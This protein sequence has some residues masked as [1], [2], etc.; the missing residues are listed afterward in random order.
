ML[1]DT[2]DFLHNSISNTRSHIIFSI[3]GILQR[4]FYING[5]IKHAAY[6]HS[7]CQHLL[8]LKCDM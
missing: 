1:F 2:F 5:V 8:V 4:T 3:S 6:A 7:A